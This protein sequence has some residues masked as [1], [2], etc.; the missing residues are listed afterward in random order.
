MACLTCNER[1]W[2]TLFMVKART[3]LS[4]R[5]ETTTQPRNEHAK[6]KR[7]S[8]QTTSPKFINNRTT[9]VLGP[10]LIIFNYT[11]YA[12]VPTPQIEM[13]TP[14]RPQ[15]GNLPWAMAGFPQFFAVV[16]ITY[17]IQAL[18]RNAALLWQREPNMSRRLNSAPPTRAGPPKSRS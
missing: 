15:I 5:A 18:Y 1:K 11:K 7:A 3:L 16:K 17:E 6:N 9:Q 8:L 4:E 10:A 14:G 13:A 12:R 2:T